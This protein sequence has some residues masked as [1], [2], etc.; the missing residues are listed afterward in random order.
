MKV[1][2]FSAEYISFLCA[3]LRMILAGGISL[4]EALLMMAQEEKDNEASKV[5]TEIGDKIGSGH[6]LDEAFA[7]CGRFP[8]HMTD[9]IGIGYKSGRLE[10]VFG[11][12]SAYYDREYKLLRSIRSAVTYPAVLLAMMFCVVLILMIKILPVFKSVFDQLGSDMSAIAKALMNAGVFMGQNIVVVLVVIAVAVAT[13]VVM[14]IKS[15]KAGRPTVFMTKKLAKKA[16]AARFASAVSMAVS[17]GL[18]L[19]ETFDVVASMD[20]DQETIVAIG[21]AQEQMKENYD[22][23]EAVAASGLYS[24]IHT[25]MISMGYRSGN[26]DQVLAEVADIMNDDV[27]AELDALAGKVEPTLVVIL[28]VIIGVILLSVMLPLMDIMSAIG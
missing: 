15:K 26:L 8:R 24:N 13:L 17:S 7:Q 5:L 23:A 1:K 19:N 3:E 20:F 16:S 11:E 28:S 2:Q 14:A 21:K 25:R 27:N 4:D 10:E 6:P 9:M 12:L 22:F 18:S